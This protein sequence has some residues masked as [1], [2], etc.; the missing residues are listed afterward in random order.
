MSEQQRSCAGV[1]RE[2]VLVEGRWVC[3]DCGVPVP[4]V[5]VDT[6]VTPR[7]EDFLADMECEDYLRSDEWDR[8]KR[9]AI[10]L[11]D[12]RCRGCNTPDNIE[13]HHR[14]YAR[15]GFEDVED[16]TVLCAACH[17]AVHLVADGRRGVVRTRSRVSAVHP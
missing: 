13:V 6:S 2:P 3:P 12:G 4:S 10:Q 15:R 7:G 17:D 16:L 11:A 8:I 1:G 5:I 9:L 14:T